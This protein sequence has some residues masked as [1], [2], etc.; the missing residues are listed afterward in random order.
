MR[1]SVTVFHPLSTIICIVLACLINIPLLTSQCSSGIIEGTVYMDKDLSG[2]QSTTEVGES[3]VYVRLYNT[4]GELISQTISS[5][6]GS[7][8]VPSLYDGEKYMVVF[9]IPNSYYLSTSNPDVGSDVQFVTSPNC[10]VNLG[11]LDT[12]SNCT[13][14]SEILLTCFANSLAPD[15]ED[16]ETIVGLTHNFDGSSIVR[17]YAKHEDT[18]PVWGLGYNDNNQMIYSSAF[19]KQHSKLTEHGH[20]AIFN[21]DLSNNPSTSLFAKLS[22]LGQAVGILDYTD[23]ND[24][25]Y[26]KQVG[27][28]GIGAL[29]FN[30][31]KDHVFVAN[32]YNNTIV[33]IDALNPSAS[34]TE[35]FVVPNPGCS[36]ADYRL[37]ALEHYESALYVGI[38]CTGETSGLESDVSFHV[39]RFDYETEIF[40]LEFS[41]DYSKGVWDLESTGAKNNQQWLTDIAFTEDGNM[42]LGISDRIGHV[43]CNGTTSRVDNQKGDIL[44]VENLSGTWVLESNGQTSKLQGSGVNNG[45]GPGGGEFFGDDFFIT[46]PT[47]QPDISLGSLF[48]MP[49]TNEVVAAVFDPIFNTYSGGLHRYNTTDGS[50]V[51]AQELY[52]NNVTNYFGKATGFGDITSRCGN[53]LP[54][55][56]NLV[57][58]DD[59]CDGYQNAGESGIAGV[60]VNMYDDA[61]SL[62]ATTITNNEG[63][64]SFSSSN[65]G[66][67]N[68]GL[69]DGMI[70]GE[71]YYITLEPSTFVQP[72]QSF[73][74]DN[75]YYSLTD[76]NPSEQVNSDALAQPM[77]CSTNDLSLV[78]T[79]KFVASAGVNTGF[80]IGMKASTNFD[81]AL[82]KKQVSTKDVKENDLITFEIKVYNQGGIVATEYELTDYLTPAFEFSESQNPGWVKTGNKVKKVIGTDLPPTRNHTELLKLKLKTTANIDDYVNYAEISYAKDQF[83]NLANDVDST[84]DDSNINDK[85]GYPETP[86]DDLYTDDGTIDED[87]HDPAR[88]AVLDLALRNV[89]QDNRLYDVDDMATFEMTVINQGNVTVSQFELTNLFPAEMTFNAS[90]NDGWNID[91]PGKVKYTYSNGIEPGDKKTFFIKLIVNDNYDFQD[92]LNL[93]EISNIVSAEAGITRDV[94]STPNDFLLDDRGGNPY[95]NTDNLITD[96]GSIDEDDHDPA[97]LTVR[98]IDLALR[99]TTNRL[100]YNPGDLAEFQI[101]IFNQ[102]EVGLGE[103]KIVDYLPEYTNVEDSSWH[104]DP[105]D[106]T[107]RTVY[108]SLKFIAGFGPGDSH[109]EFISLRIEDN[110]IP[111]Y[112]INNAEIAKVFDRNGIDVS[113]HDVDSEPDT[114]LFNDN[115]GVFSSS[116]DDVITDNGL[117][118]EDDHDPS[119]FYIADVRLIPSTTK[120]CNCLSNA[121]NIFNGQFLDSLV[122]T[123]PSGQTWYIDTVVNLFDKASPAPPS[124]P[125]PF[126]T[127]DT[128]YTLSVLSD[129]GDISQYLLEGIYEDRKTFNIRITNGEGTYIQANNTG[130]ECEYSRDNIQSPTNGLSAVCSGVSHTYEAANTT[131]CNDYVWS[132]NGGGS[133]VG[134]NDEAEVEIQWNSVPGGPYTLTLT[135]TCAGLCISPITTYIS[136]G[137]P[138]LQMSCIGSLN[139]SLNDYC[140]SQ[141]DAYTFLTSQTLPNQAYQLMI[142]DASG[143]I[144]PNNLLTEDQLW[145]TVTAKVIDPCSGN[146]CWTT[147]NVE[148]K[149]A[150]T[151]QCGN[152]SLP[153]YLLDSYEPIV[154]ENCHDDA[155]YELIEETLT[156][157]NCDLNFIKI[158][159]RQYVA[160]DGYG[161][162]SEP[163]DQVISLE[164]LP[165]DEIEYP[166]DLL[167][168]DKN[169]LIC[170]DSIYDIDGNIRFD[171]AG[172]PK[173]NGHP[174]FP[175]QDFYCN[176]GIDY[177]DFVVADFGC[178]KKIMRTWRV[179]EAWCTTGV[180][181]TPYVQ[182][183]EISDTEAPIVTC[184]S[185]VTVSSSGTDCEGTIVLDLPTIEDDCSTEFT[186]D[187]TYD[188][189]F[190]RSLKT[191][192][193]LTISA[194]I[195]KARYYVY[196]QCENIDSCTVNIEVLDLTNPV[197][198]CDENTIVSL[199]STGTAKAFAHTFDDGSYDDCSLLKTLVRRVE[200]SC[201]CQRPEFEDMNF[202]GE[203]DGRYYYLSK[204]KT[205]G[206]KAFG[207]SSAYGGMLVKFE[208]QEECEWVHE[209]TRPL[210]ASPYYIGLSDADHQDRFTWDD[211][212]DPDFN[213]F[214]GGI[215]ANVGDNVVTNSDGNWV[216]VD[217]VDVE[218][219]YVLELSDPCGFS[220]EVYFCCEDGVENQEVIFRVIDYFGRTN[221]C[222]VNVEVQDKLAPKI[223]CPDSEEIS[224]S[225]E[226]NIEDLT[227]EFGYASAIDQ[228]GATITDTLIDMRSGCAE[229][230][231][232]RRFMASDNNGASTC[233]QVLSVI[234]D[235][236]AVNNGVIWPLDFTTDMGCNST[237]LDPD[238]LAVEFGRPRFEFNACSQLVVSMDEQR[239]SFAGPGSDSCLKILRRWKIIDWCQQDSP[240]YEPL[241]YDQVIKVSNIVG[242]EILSGCDTLTVNTTECEFEDISFS[243]SANDDCTPAED[244]KAKIQL[245]LHSDG[246]GVFDTIISITN[247]EISFN[248]LLPIGNH[249]A[250]ISFED[251][252]NNVTTCTKIINVNNITLPT[253]AC[254]DGISVALEP[255]DLD[256]NG[257][258]DTERACIFPEMIDASSTHDCGSKIYLSFSADTSDTK[259][260]YEC[261]DLGIQTVEL[262]VTDIFG[263]TAF[264]TAHVDVQDNNNEDFCPRFDLALI[265]TLNTVAT[266]GPFAPG[267]AISFDV[268]VFNQGNIM[269]YDIGL[270]D[271]IPDGLTLNDSNWTANAAGTL[272]TL[273]NNIVNLEDSTSTTVGISFT[274]DNDFMGFTITNTAEISEADNDTDPNNTPLE[275]SDSVPDTINDDQGGGDDVTDSSNGDED[276][277]DPETVDV[278]QIFDLSLAKDCAD[279]GPYTPGSPITYILTVTNEGTVNASNIELEDNI[280]AGL[281]LNDTD[282]TANGAGTAATLNVPVPAVNIGQSVD[283][284]ITFTIDDMFMNESIVNTAEII[285]PNG[286]LLTDDDST[287]GND[288][289]DQSEDDE[290]F[291]E[292]VVGQ[293]FDLALVKLINTTATPGP[294]DTGDDVTFTVTVY[295]QG[296]LDATNIQVIDYVPAGMTFD[297]SKNIDFNVSGSNAL[298]TTSVD[299]DQ[300]VELSITLTIDSDFAGNSLINTSEIISAT[301]ALNLTDQ[302]DDLNK[303]NPNG[304]NPELGSN[305]DINDE[306]ASAPGFVDNPNDEDD[307]DFEA[308]D[309]N[310]TLTP[311]CNSLEML[312]IDLDANGM[313]TVTAAELSSGVNASTSSCTNETVTV[314]IIS[315]T[316]NFTC[317]NLGSGNIV[318]LQAIDSNE[319]VSTND[320]ES[321]ITIVDNIPP[322]VTCVDVTV[323]TNNAG[324]PILSSAE[325][326]SESN[327]NCFVSDTIIDLSNITDFDALQCT[328]MMATVVVSDISGNTGDCDFLITIA[329][330]P[331]VANCSNF[332]VQLDGNG[333]ATITTAE[334]D[335]NSTDD[336]TAN[337]DL[338][339]ALDNTSFDCTDVGMQTVI[340]TVTDEAGQ[341][342][343]C[344]ASI[345]VEDNVAPDA[346]CQD[347]TIQIDD[348]G[349]ATVSVFDIDNN[350]SD[351]CGMLNLSASQLSFNCME[352]G[353]NTVTLTVE[354]VNMNVSTC[355]SEV[356]VQDTINPT[357]MCNATLSV[358][359][360]TDGMATVTVDQYIS[361]SDDNCGIVSMTS[362]H[363]QEFTCDDIDLSPIAVVV[364]VMD[365]SGNVATC[366]TDV[367]I[368]D[369]EAPTCTLDT[370]VVNIDA[371][372]TITLADLD[373]DAMDN[374]AGIVSLTTNA[375]ISPSM[376]DCTDLGTNTVTVTVIDS[377][378]NDSICTAT[379]NVEDNGMPICSVNDITVNLD[380]MGNIT[381]TAEQIDNGSNVGCDLNPTLSLD[382]TQFDCSDTTAVNPVVLTIT[383]S[384]MVSEDCAANVTVQDVT[385]P[386]VDCVDD[387][388]LDLNQDGIVNI[389]ASTLIVSD[390]D[391][392]GIMA[393]VAIPGMLNCDNI[394][395]ITVVTVTVTDIS[396]STTTCENNV[397]VV[398]NLNPTCTVVP[399]LTVSPNQ[400]I[401][402][403]DLM[404]VPDDNCE[405]L[406]TDIDTTSFDCIM[407]GLHTVTVTV[408]DDS[409]NT[410]TC[411]SEVTVMDMEFPVCLS[412]ED[413]TVYLDPIGEVTIMT[414]DIDSASFT[415]CSPI[416]LS[417]SPSFYACN[418]VDIIPNITTLTVEDEEGDIA[419]CTTNVTVL[420]TISPI[421][422]CATLDTII[423][424]DNNGE[425]LLTPGGLNVTA[426]DGCDLDGIVLDVT[427]LECVNKGTPT[428]VTATATDENDNTATCTI[429]VNVDDNID[430]TCTLLSNLVL[431]PNIIITAST[432]LETFGDNCATASSTTT[433]TPNEF[434]CNQLGAQVI[435]MVVT[436]D[437]GNTG[438]CTAD[439][440][441][442]DNSMPI[443]VA[444]DTIV[445]LSITGNV[446]LVAEDID[447][448]S[449]AA[450]GNSVTLTIDQTVFNCSDIGD[451]IVTL[452][453]TASGGDSASCTATVSIIDDLPPT[454]VCPADMSV[455]C[456]TD[457]SN[458]DMFG[459]PTVSDN[460][461]VNPTTIEVD[462]ADLNVCD[463][464]TIER[465]FTAT[466]DFGNTASCM[467]TVTINAGV[468]P[469]VESDITWP[470]SPIEFTQC[471]VDAENL[472]TGLPIVDTSN[473]DC[474][475]LSISFEDFG[476]NGNECVNSFTR[477]WTVIDSCQA[478]G[479]FTFNQFVIIDDQVG[480]DVSGPMDMVIILPGG[481]CD[482]FLNLPAT[483]TDCAGGFT[484]V[485]DSPYADSNAT[486]DASGTYEVGETIVN[487]TATDACG[488]D[489]VYTYSIS[490][491]DTTI[492]ITDCAKIIATI[493]ASMTATVSIADANVTLASTNCGTTGI[494]DTSFSA[495]DPDVDILIADCT[496]VGLQDYTVYLFIGS[497]VLDSCTSLLQVVD[498]GGF[499]TSPQA[500]NIIGDVF[501]EDNRMVEDVSVELIGG[502]FESQ[503][504][505]DDGEYAFPEMSFGGTYMVKPTKDIDYLNGV[506]TLDLIGIQRHIIGTDKL[507]SPYK[508]IAADINRSGDI[509][510]VDL[511]ELRKLILGLYTELPDNTSWRMVNS[512][513]I[514]V[515]QLN[516]FVYNIPEEYEIFN[517]T[518]SMDIDFVG[519][520]VGDVNNSVVA[521]LA[522]ANIDARSARNFSYNVIESKH[523]KG[524]IVNLTFSSDELSDVSGLQNTIKV[525]EE[526]AEI[527]SFNAE[528]SEMST[529]NINNE[530]LHE[531]ILN[532]SWFKS[533]SWEESENNNVFTL[534]LKIK[535]DAYTSDVIS[536]GENHIS[537]EAYFDNQVGDIDLEFRSDLQTE[538]VLSL[539]QNVPNPWSE[540]TEIKFYMPAD[541]DVVVNIYD[542]N[543]KLIFQQQSTAKH[544]VNRIVLNEADFNT[545]GILYYEL[546]SGSSRLI[547]KMLLI[548]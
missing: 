487:V 107:G 71:V 208:T 161:N 374:C 160:T 432:V 482:V 17:S 396:G 506:S 194:G 502:P 510:S 452:T 242:P 25:N 193:T 158:I 261:D 308:V 423:F 137:D 5:D 405:V 114:E 287:P 497:T 165:I 284:E 372:A 84:P 416:M 206:S 111:G 334:V 442:E 196:D 495:S 404:F 229:G 98:L 419:T 77:S 406:M 345:T 315:G 357:V 383:G 317:V 526:L 378:G 135:P 325:I 415:G 226:I 99:K 349:V 412:F 241:T 66:R 463:V 101:T 37:F 189:G 359:L 95:D 480:P 82:T 125:T 63:R 38:T 446:V 343:T 115:G 548:K 81:L 8:I 331:P 403:T 353:D 122:I 380:V 445:S 530:K 44:M 149:N 70:V 443:C 72:N 295:N 275:D 11:L 499:C 100:I 4:S 74:I 143:N 518:E 97:I 255:M 477:T 224:C 91:V 344:S 449:T 411:A 311:I 299:S 421:I 431:P 408:T 310:C 12:N 342:D 253:A 444:Q 455:A 61:C 484:A 475:N 252:C 507:D 368:Q 509:T 138:S 89:I 150:P 504:T 202:L 22:D 238:S 51:A 222:L 422:T 186:I 80:D 352:Q 120:E 152:I 467:Q 418:N 258:P 33:K 151:I 321:N 110:V 420:D 466:D 491:I 235:I 332:T 542:I 266:P 481:D 257:T 524:S 436:D 228:C 409:G 134:P 92:I 476:N 450:C 496:F 534:V 277:H 185:S 270:V 535:A 425:A 514:F 340:L 232:I 182:T 437:C 539:Y 381:I 474:F 364:T 501:T 289:G 181:A 292:I 55:V 86:T 14:D 458:L 278:I 30:D 236:G 414:T 478:N 221:E 139:I 338:V 309:V 45:Q 217:G 461:D 519:V 274:I 379:V 355:T 545:G 140:S 529:A 180:L 329:N 64:Y 76:V 395:Q 490:I 283:V 129:D 393:R 313:A 49:G 547:N 131:G 434:D 464:G 20:D 498:G 43:Y 187:L 145:T 322:T 78:P 489:S 96:D 174:I 382:I 543:G 104:V 103:I 219:Y 387:I 26:G 167:L 339:F 312:S 195:S 168:D 459:D 371:L 67:D 65:V 399:T 347:V 541:E 271:Y 500:G 123:A 254:V 142:T 457:I 291:K 50:K 36:N 53:L 210:I 527:V 447:N 126:A 314:S 190:E 247:G 362:N 164:R 148:D 336:C 320:C 503:M 69:A 159:T 369:T 538:E 468:N 199:R 398:D 282:W 386:V 216:V 205:H 483:V 269:A 508:M 94:D 68:N 175:V 456:G 300:S 521:N 337:M 128:G 293:V 531:G 429:T 201:D 544:G 448:G 7:Y 460:C 486:A 108:K 513:F 223:T 118:D 268:Q 451:N 307:Y 6:D 9:E 373:F 209:Q 188:G 401:T 35:A 288:D 218:A 358:V 370:D 40:S 492:M 298:A 144:V 173:L 16:L 285:D 27:T 245:D 141:L 426:T 203:R 348:M 350:S 318:T 3:G 87:D 361:A 1:K 272:A 240:G 488:I 515:D 427:L 170:V 326:V 363:M 367:I 231:I 454:L 46:N 319:N 465:T 200:S 127:G 243:A 212:S 28:I 133:I 162:V 532:M 62:V 377:N 207:Y 251:Q 391:A 335:N 136:I 73:N 132:L 157:L 281:I 306:R 56:G 85:G 249:F 389:T 213:K 323:M 250:L 124:S 516:P 528:V 163:C 346:N 214:E 172:V 117:L 384:N 430:P 260:I 536:I 441:I 39:Y 522:D 462:V 41:T 341:S 234:N 356:T 239:F 59:N 215:S 360:G 246:L 424:L 453:V 256:G 106:P 324:E 227:S 155:S 198:I 79:V 304:T 211:H 533:D 225:Q 153:C 52:S 116:T 154:I 376:Y 105:S 23:P 351:A 197:A 166:A 407:L 388:T 146:S 286:L 354:D 31:A 428:I 471:I 264:C 435:T 296:S 113:G 15:Y 121:S 297:P 485:N 178:T 130:F 366:T 479:V 390:S 24:C 410:G 400:V 184:P 60:A 439:I 244:L 276:D 262:W 18:G 42:L 171:L 75:V 493:D 413:I 385:P 192:P 29:S 13:E 523:E 375:T 248:G 88:V 57:W 438:S 301:N 394:G 263:N 330:E 520:K 119:G 328:P 290:A 316:S 433:I 525:N 402:L 176:V 93:A 48:V 397:T 230:D 365:A 302:D 10:D 546:I 90:L 537:A 267:D 473:S 273:N 294:Y 233:D 2:T 333:N 265:K 469:V 470:T 279:S 47:S 540:S 204:F 237:D 112:V 183:I 54:E 327:D 494:Y 417:V 440:T 505:N 169:N 517:F 512:D 259:K 392:C 109:T 303:V 34:T 305:N 156:P 511:L 280:P 220:D 147:V 32:L 83:G 472:D 21:T 58:N 191:A 102:G 179:Y 19:V 177:E